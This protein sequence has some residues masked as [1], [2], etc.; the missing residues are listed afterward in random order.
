MQRRQLSQRLLELER[1]QR[2]HILVHGMDEISYLSEA[3][4]K[5][6]TVYTR[7]HHRNQS[8]IGFA[9]LHPNGKRLTLVTKLYDRQSA[10]L[11]VYDIAPQKQETILS[12]PYLFGPR[13]SPDGDRIAFSGRSGATGSFDLNVYELRTAK[14]S[15]IVAGELPSGEGY[16]DWS[17]DGKKIVYENVD[18]YIRIIDAQTKENRA[19]GK[20]GSPRWCPDGKQISYHKDGEVAV[21][22][23]NVESGQSRT[24]F[25][26]EKVGSPTWSPDGRYITY[27]QLYG[28][29]SKQ[30]HDL[31][32]L[33][34]TH[35]D[36]WVLDTQSG[37]EVKL[38]T[39]NES[40]YP[41]YWGPIAV[42]SAVSH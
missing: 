17:P 18:G 9:S 2:W 26:G 39:G 15:Q 33:T 12:M 14:V 13:W 38:F 27:S 8:W 4:G 31:S 28:D 21:V 35:G 10:D 41:T 3:N 29:I 22:L 1:Q 32:K 5:L 11:I 7:F 36:L 6:E 42:A 19:L 30:L 24:I 40:I 25:V 16:F 23:Q 34:D 37:V 20:G